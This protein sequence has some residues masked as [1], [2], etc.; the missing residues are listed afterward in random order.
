MPFESATR[1]VAPGATETASHSNG[2]NPERHFQ[3][4]PA[5]PVHVLTRNAGSFDPRTR[6]WACWGFFLAE[7]HHAASIFRGEKQQHVGNLHQ[8]PWSELVFAI[9]GE[10]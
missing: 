4:H 7:D 3:S 6:V 10:D 8:D 1:K 9:L 2:F 5:A